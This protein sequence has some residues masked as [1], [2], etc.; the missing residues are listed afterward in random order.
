[1]AESVKTPSLIL[2]SAR[3]DIC[4]VPDMKKSLI[5]TRI[6]SEIGID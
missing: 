6:N 2:S 3:E 4:L 1:M 5:L